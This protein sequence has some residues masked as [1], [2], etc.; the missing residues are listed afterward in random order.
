MTKK[1]GNPKTDGSFDQI[2]LALTTGLAP[3][4]KLRE[5][6]IVSC[7][8]VGLVFHGEMT[9][10]QWQQLLALFRR[11][12][13]QFH[14]A[15]AD[16]IAYGRENFG[17]QQV[18]ETLE[19]LEFDIQDT[20]RGAAISTL[21][22]GS[23]RETLTSEHHYVAAKA[24]LSTASRA[25]WLKTAEKEKLTA[26]E[27]QHSIEAGQVVKANTSLAGRGRGTGIA[28][29]EGVL[30]M[31]KQWERQVSE[32]DPIEDWEPERKRRF[33]DEVAPLEVRIRRVRESLEKEVR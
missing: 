10:E 33:L 32:T 8:S 24:D 16:M 28:T 17:E 13:N 9:L 25:G 19:Q 1:I 7:N 15:L 27:L 2:Q 21:P 6:R 30:F 3:G 4:A 11:I 14:F 26:L 29:I 23:R 12:R 22:H 20:L 5:G 18:A 31:Y